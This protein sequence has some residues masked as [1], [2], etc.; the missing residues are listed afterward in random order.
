MK[1]K[2]QLTPPDHLKI[3]KN[4]KFDVNWKKRLDDKKNS[5]TLFTRLKTL[6][7]VTT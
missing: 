1:L 3:E 5:K 6:M 7:G 4:G 2:S